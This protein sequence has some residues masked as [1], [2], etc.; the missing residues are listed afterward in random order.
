[1]QEGFHYM[2]LRVPFDKQI[3]ICNRIGSLIP[4]DQGRVFLPMYENYRRDRKEIE[5]KIM[6]TGYIFVYSNI[7][8]QTLYK[9]CRSFARPVKSFL[10]LQKDV[11]WDAGEN[12]LLDLTKDEEEFFENILD[13]HGVERMSKGYISE[14]TGKAVVVEGPLIN[15][16]DNIIKLD[17]RNWL[18]WL[19]IKMNKEPIMAGLQI[20]EKCEFDNKTS[21]Q[22]EACHP[23]M[24]V[25]S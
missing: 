12:D 11:V 19:D 6:F 14:T 25:G 24:G 5:K 1:M 21:S 2:V 23:D 8:R 20:L 10:L 13:V 4:E 9:V 3:N 15:Y 16:T 18:A 17:K 22:E 7:N